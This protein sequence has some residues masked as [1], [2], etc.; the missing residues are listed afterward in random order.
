MQA[1]ATARDD[2]SL[3]HLAEAVR[4]Q[5]THVIEAHLSIIVNRLRDALTA[6]LEEEL[7]LNVI[8]AAKAAAKHGVRRLERF[9]EWDEADHPREDNGQFGSGGGSSS[10]AGP[11]D[12]VVE[13]HGKAVREDELPKESSLAGDPN[14]DAE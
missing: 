1:V 2:V 9:A 3:V 13:S 6:R 7:R 10:S 5:S 12:F 8:A 14:E 4:S 11:G